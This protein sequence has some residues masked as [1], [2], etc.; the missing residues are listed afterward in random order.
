MASALNINLTVDYLRI[1]FIPEPRQQNFLLMKENIC[2]FFIIS[3]ESSFI[4]LPKLRGGKRAKTALI[5]ITCE[6]L[7]LVSIKAVYSSPYSLLEEIS[8]IMMKYFLMQFVKVL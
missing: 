3:F 5:Y 7:F 2:A 1:Y 8:L 4:L 6:M